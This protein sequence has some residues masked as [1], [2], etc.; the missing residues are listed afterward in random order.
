MKTLSKSL[1]QVS[2]LFLKLLWS[3]F[4]SQVQ[5]YINSHHRKSFYLEISQTS[6]QNCHLLK[7]LMS[8]IN[9]QHFFSMYEQQYYYFEINLR[10]LIQYLQNQIFKVHAPLCYFDFDLL[11]SVHLFRI[12]FGYYF[13]S[14]L[15]NF[16]NTYTIITWEFQAEKS[17]EKK[18]NLHFD[19]NFFLN[20]FFLDFSNCFVPRQSTKH[21]Q[22]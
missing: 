7:C 11:K 20:Y 5:K 14:I 21:H 4:S 8:I 18:M 2:M 3:L 15:K 12:R 6:H 19:F 13:F 9:I 10:Y 17:F 22:N 16:V 1:F